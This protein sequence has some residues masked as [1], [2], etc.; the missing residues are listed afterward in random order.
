MQCQDEVV[1]WP[2]L[3]RYLATAYV[4]KINQEQCARLCK[5]LELGKVAPKQGMLDWV[6]DEKTDSTRALLLLVMFTDVG[7]HHWLDESDT[8]VGLRMVAEE[9]GID[10]ELVKESVKS[11]TRAA[12]KAA[13][14]AEAAQS[15]P[16]LRP[17]AQANGAR[18]KA[19]A[20]DGPAA[21]G[22]RKGESGRGRGK[23]KDAAPTEPKAREED[24]RSGIAAAMRGLEDESV[25]AAG[26]EGG[27]TRPQAVA[28]GRPADD[29]EAGSLAIG[30][31]VLILDSPLG[32]SGEIV[33]E[34]GTGEW[35]VIPDGKLGSYRFDPDEL[36]LDAGGHDVEA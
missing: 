7:Y 19:V 25:A 36:E 12:V 24:V 18:G 4:H 20:S 28:G 10:I 11:A 26:G 14:A 22:S 17:A 33:D 29:S 34:I 30:R 1:T 31:R 2:T 9:F 21:R 6:K 27:G 23:R 35:L 3:M 5:L 15:D 32:K 16:P 13:K 8:N